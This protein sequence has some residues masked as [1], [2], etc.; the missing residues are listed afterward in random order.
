MVQGFSS[1]AQRGIGLHLASQ[2]HPCSVHGSPSRHGALI[3]KG[4]AVFWQ[5]PPLQVATKQVPPSH[6]LPSGTARPTQ[7]APILPSEALGSQAR[8]KHV[9]SAW[10]LWIPW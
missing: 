8:A 2:H 10:Q 6:Q 9:E 1:L 7:P 3:T 5:D 4:I